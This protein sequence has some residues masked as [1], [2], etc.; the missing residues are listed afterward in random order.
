MNIRQKVLEANR[1]IVDK[2]LVE[3]TWGNVSAKSNNLVY[4]K[5]SGINLNNAVDSDVSMVNID[6][7]YAGGLKPSVDTP[8]HLA[9]Y[10][11]FKNIGCVVHTHSKYS[12]IFAQAGRDIP[13]LGTTHA[14][15]FYGDIPCV[16]HPSKKLV[17]NDYELNTGN[18]IVEH[19]HKN[20]IKY[21]Y[22]PACIVSGHGTF[23][24]GENIEKALENVYVLEIIAE[25]AYK[26]LL[27]NPKA[28]LKK[29]VLDKHYL[30]KHGDNKYYGQ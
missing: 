26:T 4:I 8:T 2:K 30:R 27:L 29:Y 5:P 7:T 25:M 22:M 28:S 24:W 1:W 14:D 9:L 17:K 10:R 11:S 6:G 20:D 15:Y 12:T 13:C 23:V 21:D 18:L 16:S 19:Y 3:L